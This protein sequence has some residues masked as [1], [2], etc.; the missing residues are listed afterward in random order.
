[1][2]KLG[3]LLLLVSNFSYAQKYSPEA[4]YFNEDYKLTISLLENNSNT[5]N[6]PH[7]SLL[8]AL[9]LWQLHLLADAEQQFA[10]TISLDQE[11]F[12]A[13]FHYANFLIEIE[14]YDR[15]LFVLNYLIN[16]LNKAETK[17]IIFKI[18]KFSQEPMQIS[19]LASMKPDM[20]SRR[21]K[22]YQ[23]LGRKEEAIEDLNSAISLNEGVSLIVQRGLIWSELGKRDLAENDF[24]YAIRLEPFSPLAWYNLLLVNPSTLIPNEVEKDL[25]FAPLLAH[26]AILNMN[27]GEYKKAK[28][29]LYAAINMEPR[30][31]IHLL[32]L[33][34]LE[35][36][37]GTFI[38]AI[39]LFEKAINLDPAKTE[40]LYLIGNA[41]FGLKQY[42]KA[43]D[44][45]RK[46]LLTDPTYADIWYNAGMSYFQIGEKSDGCKCL[47][48]ALEFGMMRAKAVISSNCENE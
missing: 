42:E 39:D 44:Y 45:Y 12:E 48:R 28:S 37:N 15:S 13:Y 8:K 3:I 36:K 41:Y 35:S 14:Q 10:K 26:N 33:G 6:D 16:N 40:S 19:S 34:R 20:L 9:S 29:L 7:L 25:S 24:N 31:A 18:D 43:I 21:A 46:Y 5:E 38:Q 11:Y 30:N 32:N 22:V 17:S 1:M 23:L 27:N 2:R 47:K 4:A